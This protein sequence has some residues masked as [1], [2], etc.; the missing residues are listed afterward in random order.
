[1]PRPGPKVSFPAEHLA[2]LLRL[3][4]GNTKMKTDL[5]SQ[6]RD[7]FEKVSTKAAIEAKIKEVATRQGKA[8]DSQWKVRPEAW[9][10]AGVEPP[11]V[12]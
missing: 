7:H 10:A 8:K 3:I 11:E 9:V 4:E 5:V 6:L 12:V 1:R 2:E